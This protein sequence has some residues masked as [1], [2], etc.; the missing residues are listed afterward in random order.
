MKAEGLS[1]YEIVT[2]S[3]SV[4]A[5]VRLGFPV[6]V[7]QLGAIFVG[8][9]DTLMIGSYGTDELA[10]AA[11][12]NNL[13]MVPVVM[14]IGF[15]GGITPLVGALFGKKDHDGV[16]RT[17]RM[18]IRLNI[19]MSLLLTA[20]MTVLFFFLDKMGQD[21]ALLPLVRPYYIL[22]LVSVP[23]SGLFFACQ[24]T[25]NGVNDT[26]TPMWIILGANLLNVIGNYALIF[27]HLGAPEM[28]LA[29][30]GVSTLAA[31]IVAAAVI[32]LIVTRGSRFSVYNRGYREGGPAHDVD[33]RRLVNTSWPLMFQSGIE[34]FLWAFGAVVSGWFGK[35]QLA[36]YQVV[37]TINQ[38]GFMTYISAG[39]AV[40][41]RV[42]NYA[43]LSDSG[44]MRVTARAG[45]HIC[46]ILC[47]AASLIFIFLGK[48]VLGLFTSDHA[49]IIA[50]GLLILPLVLYQFGDATQIIYGNALRGTSN[51][52]PMLWISIIC[53]LIIGVP[54]MLL[55]ASGLHMEGPGVY[56]SFSAAVFSAALLY[57]LS[58]R[59]TINKFLPPN[60]LTPN[61]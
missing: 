51:V 9:A 36:A 21:P 35:H 47:V 4:R 25:S 5:L 59:T 26:A 56:Y 3:N 45:L 40:A 61:P 50:G 15:A 10:A 6:L 41:I 22:V 37:L 42:S 1:K 33:M 24:Q 60:P 49:V 58:F 7:T 55:L 43:G 46:L 34:C 32:W 48:G 54:V 12:V 14:L 20:V 27:G 16:G 17:M 19:A 8:F 18:A 13:F 44:A 29:G 57:F 31:R 11:F 52:R 30:A 39:T 23:V 53:Y 38:I 2:Y 28:G